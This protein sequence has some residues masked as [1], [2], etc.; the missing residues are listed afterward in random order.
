VITGI[1]FV[2]LV[3]ILDMKATLNSNSHSIGFEYCNF[4]CVTFLSPNFSRKEC[5]IF[6]IIIIYTTG[7][8]L[9]IVPKSLIRPLFNP[10]ALDAI[11]H[12]ERL[13]CPLRNDYLIESDQRTCRVDSQ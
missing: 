5:M 10:M 13:L 8:V 3:P 6:I 1:A 7:T 12:C 2:I 11:P 9:K 4:A